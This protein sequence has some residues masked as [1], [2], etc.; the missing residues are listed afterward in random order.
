MKI[1][2]AAMAKRKKFWQNAILQGPVGQNKSVFVT[3]WVPGG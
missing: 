1:V 3:G 2:W